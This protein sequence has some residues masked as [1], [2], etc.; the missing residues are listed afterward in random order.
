MK[1]D[2]DEKPFCGTS[3][4]IETTTSWNQ[5]P[6]RIAS[7]KASAASFSCK[8]SAITFLAVDVVASGVTSWESDGVDVSLDVLD[9]DFFFFFFFL[10][11]LD[12][13]FGFTAEDDAVADDFFF[14]E[15]CWA[16][17]PRRES[18][19]DKGLKSSVDAQSEINPFEA[20]TLDDRTEV[21]AIAVTP[22]AINTANSRKRNARWKAGMTCRG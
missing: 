8:A 1:H 2:E 16:A 4:I 5:K 3:C 6:Y 9:L 20:R 12:V 15:G 21:R 13:D 17:P 11:S 14:F 22:A 18:N 10:V 7:P 19:N